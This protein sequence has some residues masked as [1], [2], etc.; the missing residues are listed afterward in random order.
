MKKSISSIRELARAVGRSHTSVREWMGHPQWRFR[1]G[2]WSA[3][4]VEEIRAWAAATLAPNPAERAGTT[5][6]DSTEAGTLTKAKLALTIEKARTAKF[7]REKK[8]GL[9]HSISECE[10]RRSR[11]VQEVREEFTD[12]AP[13]AIAN[14]VLDALKAPR[15]EATVATVRSIVEDEL[16]AICDR[17]AALPNE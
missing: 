5:A 12:R 10:S 2:P 4:Q 16:R 17:F 15:D 3:E 7:E 14:R 11:Q 1:R 9:Y 13:A 6:A 8:Q